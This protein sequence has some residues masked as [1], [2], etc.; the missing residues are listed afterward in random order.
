MNR[1]K[2]IFYIF[3]LVTIVFAGFLALYALNIYGD[4]VKKTP[5]NLFADPTST[6]TIKVV[7]INA[8]GWELPFRSTNA[9]F[10][11]IE[12]L[13]LVEIIELNSE[14]GFLLLR[15]KGIPGIV[16]ISIKTKFSL[17][18]NLVRVEILTLTG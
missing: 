9:E 4:V 5:K 11:V 13:D 8:L 7:P 3:L 14:S 12:G 2:T 1:R 6:M 16:E 10:T 17:L 18:P 15:S